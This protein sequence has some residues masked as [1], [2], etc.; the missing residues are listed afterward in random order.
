M[1]ALTTRQ[2]ETISSYRHY[3]LNLH[4]DHG[5]DVRALTVTAVALEPLTVNVKIHGDSVMD[6]GVYTTHTFNKV[7]D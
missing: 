7:I 2:E 1:K 3:L 4:A 6:R 5:V